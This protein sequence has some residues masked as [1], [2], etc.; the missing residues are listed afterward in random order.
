MTPTSHTTADQVR[1]MGLAIGDVIVGRE[2][3]GSNWRES[4]LTLLFVGKKVAVFKERCRNI[5]EPSWQDNGE[6]ATW[7]LAHRD[8]KLQPKAAS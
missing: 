8:W 3:F 7:T 1:E 5:M 2:T 6:T 4:E